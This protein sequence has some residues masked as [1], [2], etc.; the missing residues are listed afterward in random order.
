MIAERLNRSDIEQL[1]QETGCS[2][3]FTR[4]FLTTMDTQSIPEQLKLLRT[5]RARQL[6]RLHKEEKHLDQ[7]D[8]LRYALEQQN[9]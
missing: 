7:L 5:Q 1:L 4:Q 8:F 3:D 9:L 6:E 2:K